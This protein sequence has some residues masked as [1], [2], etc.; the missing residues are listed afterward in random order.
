MPNEKKENRID[1]EDLPLA[2]QELTP[3]EAQDVKGGFADGTFGS[4]VGVGT[5]DVNNDDPAEAIT[6]AE[7]NAGPPI[8]GG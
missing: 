1:I 6:G 7:P 2:E 5:G 4:G 3:E 8:K